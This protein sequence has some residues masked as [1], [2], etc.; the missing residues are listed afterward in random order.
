MVCALVSAVCYGT[1]SALQAVASR[2]VEPGA[3][4]GLD[5]ALLWRVLRQPRFLVGLALD[6]TGFAL[7]IVA[8]RSIPLYA[9]SAALAASLAVTAVVATRLLP[10]RLGGAEWGAVATVCAGLAM[11]GLASGTVG[12]GTGPP[13]LHWYLLAAPLAALLAAAPAARLPGRAR[14]LLLGLGAGVGFGVAETAV[15]L[16][17]SPTVSRLIGDPAVYALALGGITGFLLLTSAY[18]RGSVAV[19]T[20]GMVVAETI[21]PALVGLYWFGDHPRAGLEW[22]AFTGFGAAVAGALALARFG[23]PP[24]A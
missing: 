4:T 6:I 8:L 11:I 5:P 18:Q 17:G 7:Q 2:A 24:K 16:I 14:A 10:V 1:A 13:A 21:G 20:A 9:A 15:R 3:G 12:S 23:E 19:A 22:L